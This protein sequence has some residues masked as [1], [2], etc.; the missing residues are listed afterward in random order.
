MMAMDTARAT[1]ATTPAPATTACPGAAASR[2]RARRVR[3]A[4]P[5][6]R[7]RIAQ[8]VSPGKA[9]TAPTRMRPTAR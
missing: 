2:A 9:S 1:L 4:R 8:G 6:A 5:P 3:M 7:G